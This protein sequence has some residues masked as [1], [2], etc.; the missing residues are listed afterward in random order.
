M[1]VAF[2]F[3]LQRASRASRPTIRSLR[4]QLESSCYDPGNREVFVQ[5]LPPQRVTVELDPN[6][7]QLL[8]RR[9]RK[10]SESV[11]GKTDDASVVKFYVDRSLLDPDPESDRLD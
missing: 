5:F 10:D 7:R 11:S 1:L 6:L 3:F 9:L 8:L 4:S 2:Y